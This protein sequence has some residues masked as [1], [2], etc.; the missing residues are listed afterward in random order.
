LHVATISFTG[1]GTLDLADNT[2]IADNSPSTVFGYYTSGRIF[3]S[4][5]ASNTALGAAFATDVYSSFPETF[6]GESIGSTAVLVRYTLAGDS[7]LDRSVDTVDFGLLVGSFGTLSGARW[8][9]GDYNQD[10]AVDTTDF[11]V[12]VGNFSQTLV[13]APAPV[14]AAAFPVH[15]GF[16][17]LS[18]SERTDELDLL[19]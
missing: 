2:F 8:S 14:A 7:N 6:A 5:S 17:S 19:A 13:A 10:G 12:L 1:G 3:T 11:N 16:S 15:S 18:V 4:V 9:Q